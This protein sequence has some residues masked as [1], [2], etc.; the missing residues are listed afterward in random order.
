MIEQ[1]PSICYQCGKCSAGCPVHYLM[2]IPPNVVIRLLQLGQIDR[3]LES[4]TIWVC[5]SCSTCSTRC[6]KEFKIAECMDALRELALA[7][8]K[9]TPSE[10]DIKLFHQVFMSNMRMFGKVHE[11]SIAGVYKLKSRHFFADVGAGIKMFLKGKIKLFPHRIKGVKEIR[12]MFEA[13]GYGR[14]EKEEPSTEDKE[15]EKLI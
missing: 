7:T 12:A 11:A 14:K 13:A 8:G 10:K 6:P 3:V 9:D 5:S 1:S 2:D 15:Q 4:R